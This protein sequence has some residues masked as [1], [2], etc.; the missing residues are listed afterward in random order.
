MF[1]SS[2][3]LGLGNPVYTNMDDFLENFR[4]GGGHIRS[5][6]FHCKIFKM[7][8]YNIFKWGR[9]T[10]QKFPENSSIL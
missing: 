8:N 3:W 4:G 1:N 10:F 7:R 5:K 9:G 6:K 2:M